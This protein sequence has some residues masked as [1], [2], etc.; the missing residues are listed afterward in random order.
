MIDDRTPVIVGTGQYNARDLGSEPIDLM[1]RCVDA[2][3]EDAGAPALRAAISAVRVVWGVWPYADPGRLVAARVGTPGARTTLTTMGGNQVYDLVNDTAARIQRGELEVALICAA[4]TLRTRRHDRANGRSTVYVAEP[5][6]VSPDETFGDEHPMAT[7]AERALGI[8]T[9]ANFYAMAETAI[10]HRNGET[11]DAHRQRIASLWAAGSTVAANNPDAWFRRAVSADEIA[12]ESD[13]NRPVASPYP[14]L[15]TANLNVDQGGAVLICSAAAAARA[16][17]PPERWVFPW[18]GAGAADHWYPTNR[19][20]FDESPAMRLAGGRALTLAG[21]G[22]DECALVD[23]YSCFPAA[24]QVAQ[25]ELGIS[26]DRDWTITGGLT[27][28]AGP[29]NCYCV[30]PLVRAVRLLRESPG[31]RAFLTGNG[32]YFTKHS[33]LVVAGEP[34]AK[35]FASE[36]VQTEVDALPSRPAPTD[37]PAGTTIETYTV[38][39]GR[40]G[41]PQRAIVACLDE[42]G[43]RHWAETRDADELE[44]L[45]TEDCCGTPFV[46]GFYVDG[47]GSSPAAR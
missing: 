22:V 13:S 34:P 24:V 28:A 16:G 41:T 25:R 6:G 2:A 38:T 26:P 30:L 9:A 14:K 21:L 43:C 33:M 40:D 15:M 47:R 18:S 27:F 5:E 39:Y 19:W 45:L 23:L 31:N 46:S 10:R 35:S 42:A 11:V 29:L 1:A 12:A 8:D 7:S 4:E 32:G 20:A 44:R 3:L 17:V 37:R 36:S